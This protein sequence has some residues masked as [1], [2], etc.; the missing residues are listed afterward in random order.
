[1]QSIKKIA[2]IISCVLFVTGLLGCAK[3]KKIVRPITMPIDIV[4]GTVGAVGAVL[5]P[6]YASPDAK[7]A[8]TDFENKTTKI[9]NE[10]SA[11]LRKTLV[12]ALVDSGRFSVIESSS[13]TSDLIIAV[14]VAEF[15]PRVSGGK[16]GIGGGGGAGSGALGALLG[17][18][19]SG[20]HMSLDIRIVDASTSE[21]L[22]SNRVRG[23]ASDVTA[24]TSGR[25]LNGNLSIYSGT[26][27]EKA[28]HICISEAVRYITSG[29]PAKYYK[30]RG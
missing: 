6:P 30:Y 23:R 1:M 12:N 16:A 17:E 19:F 4:A 18:S 28:I 27:M 21:V 8:V 7:I 15:E 22:A 2:L 29:I 5:L 24:N 26:P 3:L 11:A 20:A 13:K 9:T 25:R 14:A 10:A